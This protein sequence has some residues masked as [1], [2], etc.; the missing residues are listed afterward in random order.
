[1]GGNALKACVTRRLDAETYDIL[2]AYIGALLSDMDLGLRF[3]VIRSYSAKESHGDMDILVQSD[4]LPPDFQ[5][6]IRAVFSPKQMVR[7]GNCLSF[8]Y[9][10]FQIDL[11]LTPSHDY[12][13]ARN[14]YAYNDMGNF[15]GRIA[16]SMG[17]KLGHTGLSYGWTIGTYEFKKEIIL[18]NWSDILI[19]LGYDPDVYDKGFENLTD[20]FEFVASG[21]FFNPDLFCLADR[22]HAARTRDAKRKTYIAFLEWMKDGRVLPRYPKHSAE[23]WLPY[24]FSQVP[25]FRHT[26]ARVEEEREAALLLKTKFNGD[27]VREWTGLLDQ[28]LGK[29]M[30]SFRDAHGGNEGIAT[31][32]VDATPE[33]VK[34]F[35][36]TY[37][38]GNH[39]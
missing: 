36:L 21:S 31:L 20:I 9:R 25:D 12:D 22:N 3:N 7:N 5:E 33:E 2:V 27:L 39:V 8:E 17:V 4:G 6:R 19:V 11:I 34:N 14:Y 24:L 16:N 26:Y 29:F 10:E 1:M 32:F 28:T 15:L 23:S 38:R 18:S 35:V 13:M 30:A 37:Y